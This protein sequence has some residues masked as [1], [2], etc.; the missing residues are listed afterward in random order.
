MSCKLE[1]ELTAYLD[2]ELAPAEVSAVRAHLA[3]CADCRSTE[4]LLRDTLRT[5]E[6][7]PAFE[8]SAGLRRTVLQRLDG[9]PAS[10]GERLRALLRPGVLLPSGAALLAAGVVAVLLASPGRRGLPTELQETGALEVAMNYE[11]L[12]DYEVLGLE[13]PEDV[14]VVAQLEQLERRP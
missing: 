14:E 7:L 13:S 11:L 1:T 12:R 10:F 4:A 6:A 3:V 2:G 5:L 9:Q 8:P